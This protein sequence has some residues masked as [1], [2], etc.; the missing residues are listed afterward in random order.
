MWVDS[1]TS[2][3]IRH[4][5]QQPYSVRHQESYINICIS[6]VMCE[7]NST[8]VWYCNDIKLNYLGCLT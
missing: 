6:H 1:Q 2:I 4:R 8:V 7:F 5:K 3:L